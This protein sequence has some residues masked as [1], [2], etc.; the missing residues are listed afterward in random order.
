MNSTATHC[1]TGCDDV[2]KVN[3]I[4]EVI[5]TVYPFTRLLHSDCTATEKYFSKV[6]MIFMFSKKSK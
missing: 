6:K 4:H 1:T 3:N 5:V 2:C